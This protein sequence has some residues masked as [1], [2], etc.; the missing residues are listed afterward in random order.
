MYRVFIWLLWQCHILRFGLWRRL[1]RR[2]PLRIGLSMG[3]FNPIHLWHLQVAQCVWAFLNL[4]FILFISNGDPP[5]KEGVIGKWL[6]FRMMRAGVRG[7]CKFKTS[8]MEALRPGKSYTAD[9]LRQLKRIYGRQVELYLII[10]LDNAH[11]IATWVRAPEIFELCTLAIAPRNAREYVRDVTGAMLPGD[12][13]NANAYMREVIGAMLPGG[14]RFEVVPSPDSNVSSTMIRKW[15][16]QGMGA[17][18]DYLVPNRVR[19]IINR[20]R[21]YVE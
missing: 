9:T 3:T 21:L 2:R 18:A 16:G 8:P 15:I 12:A 6:R 13:R 19:K 11:Q 17:C 14:A 1:L 4:D 5:H 10:G 7:N 20:H